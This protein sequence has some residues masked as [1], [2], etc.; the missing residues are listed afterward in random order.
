MR[1]SGVNTFRHVKRGAFEN[2]PVFI[3]RQAVKPGPAL[4]GERFQPVEGA[5][6]LESP[7]R[8]THGSLGM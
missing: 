6:F 7:T 3:E 1:V 8:N 5:F 4:R 2:D